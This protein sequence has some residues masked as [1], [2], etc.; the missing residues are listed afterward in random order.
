MCRVEILNGFSSRPLKVKL[1]KAF[2]QRWQFIRTGRLHGTNHELLV[3]FRSGPSESLKTSK[4]FFF[5]YFVNDDRFVKAATV[6]VLSIDTLVFLVSFTE[7][8]GPNKSLNQCSYA[9]HREKFNEI[10]L[11][12]M[13]QHWAKLR[14]YIYTCYYKNKL[15]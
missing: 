15:A 14:K 11:Y 2:W 5:S 8:Y 10:L 12:I 4:Q 6:P 3:E 7:A 9:L 13:T 1:L